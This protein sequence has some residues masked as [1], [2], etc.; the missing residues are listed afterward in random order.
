[1]LIQE[2]LGYT[3]HGLRVV[4]KEEHDARMKFVFSQ[5]LFKPG[6]APKP[7]PLD[8]YQ[9][10]TG[11]RPL[12]ALVWDRYQ[13]EVNRLDD[14]Y[15]SLFRWPQC[16][17][18]KRYTQKKEE[19]DE[20]YQRQRSWVSMYRENKHDIYRA[21]Q[22]AAQYATVSVVMAMAGTLMLLSGKPTVQIASAFMYMSSALQLFGVRNNRQCQKDLAESNKGIRIVLEDWHEKDA[23]ARY[24]RLKLNKQLACLNKEKP[25]QDR[26]AQKRNLVAD[27]RQ[28]HPRIHPRTRG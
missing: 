5:D 23:M 28:K 3:R 26:R 10:E 18:M 27:Y 19:L 16:P 12:A 17:E 24:D 4:S 14:T 7:K 9:D 13:D 2:A 15:R 8:S 20:D 25:T 21:S 1:M 22:R 6:E 11:N